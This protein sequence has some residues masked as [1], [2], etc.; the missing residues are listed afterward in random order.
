VFDPRTAH[1]REAVRKADSRLAAFSPLTPVSAPWAARGPHQTPGLP[2]WAAV[3]VWGARCRWPSSGGACRG[4]LPLAWK[5]ANSVVFVVRSVTVPEKL[6]GIPCID[7]ETLPV[8]QATEWLLF[9]V[10][11]VTVTV[12]RPPVQN[13]VCCSV[14]ALPTP[15]TLG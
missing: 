13:R 8:P 12:P 5:N 4:P 9:V 14:P 7:D 10:V 1:F 2:N 11:T 15:A 6:T 3:P